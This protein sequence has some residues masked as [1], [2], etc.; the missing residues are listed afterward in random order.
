MEKNVLLIVVDALRADRVSHNGRNTLTPN[1][2]NIAHE[3]RYYE[4]CYCCSDKTTTSIPTIQTG[5]YPTRHGLLSHG[6]AVTEKQLEIFSSTESIQDILAET[7]STICID[8][9][10]DIITRGFDRVFPHDN[11]RKER[12]AAKIQSTIYNSYEKIIELVSKSPGREFGS[13]RPKNQRAAWVTDK[14]IKE[15][16]SIERPW[17]GYIHYWDTHMEYTSEDRHKKAV[18]SK[19]YSDGDT[20]INQIKD[21]HPN[22]Y[23]SEWLNEF[24]DIRT[25]G[26]LKRRYDAAVMCVDEYIGRIVNHLES[27]GELS[28]TMVIITSDHGESLTENGIYFDHQ[29]LYEPTWH[30]PLIIHSS[31]YSGIEEQ[32]VQHF[33]L[34][35]TILEYLDVEY[36]DRQ[37]DGKS[38]YPAGKG[39]NRD[40][41]FAE[42]VHNARQQ[43]IR[44]NDHIFIRNLKEDRPG[45]LSDLNRPEYQL[46][47]LDSDQSRTSNIAE[48]NPELCNKLDKKIDEWLSD[49][50]NPELGDSDFQHPKENADLMQRLN[51]LGYKFD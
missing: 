27:T 25:V 51:S 7:H 3:G 29:E 26:D 44:T 43:A 1:I 49:I 24:G 35:P 12:P 37:F 18:K 33:D 6:P 16:N 21:E 20:T 17:Y 23:V 28:N 19:K 9:L 15:I 32:F 5:L 22:S 50:P 47:S 14:F 39:L 45:R 4:S 34:V 30:V 40:A 10:G 8:V 42:Q 36:D 13:I 2:S 31:E 46:Y 11:N 41:V 48:H 38:I